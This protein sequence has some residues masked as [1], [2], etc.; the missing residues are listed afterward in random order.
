M[1][2]DTSAKQVDSLINRIIQDVNKKYYPKEDQ[3]VAQRLNDTPTVSSLGV[4]P[5]GS[6]LLDRALG[7]GGFPR[8]RIVELYGHEGSG[9]TTIGLHAIAEAQRASKE[10]G[11]NKYVLFVDAEHALDPKYAEAIGVDPDRLILVQPDYAE[12][13]L[14]IVAEFVTS[15]AISLFVIDSVAALMPE[16]EYKGA[17]DDQH[18]G[19]QARVMSQ[20]LRKL[21]GMMSRHGVLGIFINQVREKIGV[22]FG[23]PET[24]PGGRALKFWS[25]I[26]LACIAKKVD[27]DQRNERAG[28]KIDVVKNKVAPPHKSIETEIIFGQGI[29]TKKEIIGICVDEGIVRKSGSWY[30]YGDEKLGQGLENVYNFFDDNP[31]VYDEVIQKVRSLIY[32]NI[33]SLPEEDND[34]DNMP[35]SN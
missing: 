29:D 15:G 18:I 2:E 16:A 14:S 13:A 8:G 25:T 31:S 33:A 20:A 6:F 1:S 5:T 27:S 24:T 22:M 19:R 28:L 32:G 7:I 17:M 21:N 34:D 10:N 30:F 9:K 11:D 35:S 3:K 26:R 12:Q 23:N 4:I